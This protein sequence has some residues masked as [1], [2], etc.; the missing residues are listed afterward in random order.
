LDIHNNTSPNCRALGPN[1]TLET[2]A[3]DHPAELRFYADSSNNGNGQTATV[4]YSVGGGGWQLLESF[5]VG[6]GG[7]VE[8]IDLSTSPDLSG[9]SAV[10]FRFES[11]FFTW[12]LDDV[13][14][15]GVSGPGLVT[16]YEDKA[17]GDTRFHAVESLTADTRYYFRV[18][19]GNEEGVSENSATGSV[20]T[21]L[22]G[23][24]FS[25]WGT[26]EGIGAVTSISDSDGDLQTDFAEFVF[27][28]DPTTATVQSDFLV[29]EKI[30][31]SFVVTHRKS[32]APNLLWE[33]FGTSLLSNFGLP[34]ETGLAIGQYEIISS[35]DF[36]SYEEIE[37]EVN[38]GTAAN[39]FFKI[40]ATELP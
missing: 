9:Q 27:A 2:P 39:Y 15:T 35:S 29:A 16:G 19:A 8:V 23:T 4:S 36:G 22:S 7:N 21:T 30:G 6:T 38:S 25:V 10:R 26:D 3:V 33:Y 13:L 20:E 18:R 5:V 17:V 37:L 24:P 31:G 12:Y 14:V 34:L 1:D 28:T 40:E 11:T 32:K